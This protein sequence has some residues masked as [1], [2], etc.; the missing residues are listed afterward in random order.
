MSGELIKL[1]LNGAPVERPRVAA[2]PTRR[3]SQPQ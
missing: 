2:P 3:R 1:R